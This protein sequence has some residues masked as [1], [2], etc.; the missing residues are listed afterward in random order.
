MLP[1]LYRFA[2]TNGCGVAV[3]DCVVL[4]TQSLS[5]TRY[6]SRSEGCVSKPY[7]RGF[8]PEWGPFQ[9]RE[10]DVLFPSPSSE[11]SFITHERP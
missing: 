8:L 9:V 7:A 5:F 6:E 10:H 2:K 11:P 1:V 4:G 3:S